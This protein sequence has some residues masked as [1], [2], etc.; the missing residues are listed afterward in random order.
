MERKIL[1]LNS[2][3]DK[4]AEFLYYDRKE[5]EELGKYDITEAISNHEIT[6]DEMVDEFK[7]ELTANLPQ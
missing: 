4:V 2:I 6:I 1:I 5:D 7:T 3:S